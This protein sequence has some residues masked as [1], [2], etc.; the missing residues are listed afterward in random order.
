MTRRNVIPPGL[1][2]VPKNAAQLLFSSGFREILRFLC[3][4]SPL[5][6][7]IHLF[8]SLEFLRNFFPYET[9]KDCI[10]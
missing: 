1:E 8:S 9:Q 7:I 4:L 5:A 3:Q 6:N 10:L 2:F